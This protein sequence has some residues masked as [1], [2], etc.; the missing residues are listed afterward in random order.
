TNVFHL[1]NSYVGMLCLCGAFGGPFLYLH[2]FFKGIPWSF[3]ESAMI[4]GA[5]DYRIFLQ[6][7][8]PLAKNG[9][10]V[11]T[12]MKFMGYWNEYWQ[13]FLYYGQ[14]PTLAVG[15]QL[16]SGLAGQGGL[17]YSVFFAGTILCIIP[18]LIFYAI[19]SDKLMSNLNAGGIKG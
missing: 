13:A 15:L 7:M 3:A 8:L 18:V 10:L 2:S 9:V 5:S 17:P 6:I 11:F 4:D 1:R 12:I 16:L 14:H 19:F